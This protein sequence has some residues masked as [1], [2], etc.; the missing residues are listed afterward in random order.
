M[1]IYKVESIH[2]ETNI[3]EI[4][5]LEIFSPNDFELQVDGTIALFE[6]KDDAT[7]MHYVKFW[8]RPAKLKFDKPTS[9]F[10]VIDVSNFLPLDFLNGRA[11][12]LSLT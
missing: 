3:P 1:T 7:T 5:V 2:L 11:L 9:C 4:D 12:F 8:I 6:A 10:N